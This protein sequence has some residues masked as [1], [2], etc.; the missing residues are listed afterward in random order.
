MTEQEFQEYLQ[1]A[2]E[3]GRAPQVS[4]AMDSPDHETNEAGRYIAEGHALLPADYQSMPEDV[5]IDAGKLL[6]KE[7]VELK[8]KETI[9]I[10]LAHQPSKI[11][12]EILREYN[13]NPDE[14]LRF[15]AHFALEECEM[16]NE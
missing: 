5:M 14:N 2:Y 11:A 1:K 15:F 10:L 9:L 16:W 13:G 6:F 12:L 4:M 8:T 7:K 3:K